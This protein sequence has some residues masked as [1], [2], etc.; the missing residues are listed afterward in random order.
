MKGDKIEIL[1]TLQTKLQDYI[2]DVESVGDSIDFFQNEKTTIVVAC[3]K[4]DFEYIH[5]NKKDND[6]I[7]IKANPLCELSQK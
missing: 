5:K 4:S 1:K 6:I 3:S 7:I 2:N